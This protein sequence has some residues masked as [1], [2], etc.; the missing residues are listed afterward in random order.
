MKGYTALLRLQLISRFADLKPKNI[1][2]AMKENKAS[3]AAF[4]ERRDGHG[5]EAARN[6]RG[7]FAPEPRD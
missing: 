4:H 3:I 1:R 6:A 7:K 5:L 2:A